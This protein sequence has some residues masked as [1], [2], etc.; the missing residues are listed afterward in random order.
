[1]LHDLILFETKIPPLVNPP[2]AK[3]FLSGRKLQKTIRPYARVWKGCVK[4][5]RENR[6]LS[7]I[8][9]IYDSV[10]RTRAASHAPIIHP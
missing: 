7:P 10:W 6:P 3:G 4:K 9:R 1:M 8:Y 2:S 5:N